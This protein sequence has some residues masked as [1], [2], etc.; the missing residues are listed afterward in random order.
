MR[1]TWKSTSLSLRFVYV[2]G[3]A[4]CRNSRVGFLTSCLTQSHELTNIAIFSPSRGMFY[5]P[6]KNKTKYTCGPPGS[7]DIRLPSVTD[8]DLII[9]GWRVLLLDWWL[10][11]G[12]GDLK[13]SHTL[14]LELT[15]AAHRILK[16]PKKNVSNC[17]LRVQGKR[18]ASTMSGKR[19]NRLLWVA[20]CTQVHPGTLTA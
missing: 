18:S 17:D 10:G 4:P 16:K 9:R 7:S 8:Q 19:K 1:K 5:K 3:C 20:V 2:N 12:T 14:A 13:A 6:L 15:S 11:G